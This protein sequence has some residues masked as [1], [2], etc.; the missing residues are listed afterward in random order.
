LYNND[1]S[2]ISPGNISGNYLYGIIAQRRVG[3]ICELKFGG[4]KNLIQGQ[5]ITVGTVDSRLKPTFPN[6]WKV[7][8]G[9]NTYQIVVDE[10]GNITVFAYGSTDYQNN[11]NPTIVYFAK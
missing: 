5:E 7:S 3:I 11:V 1:L 6:A 2:E 9:I 10:S 8:D 4:F